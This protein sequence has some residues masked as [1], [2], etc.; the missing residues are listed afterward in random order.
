MACKRCGAAH[1]GMVRCKPE[2]VARMVVNKS[3]VANK[4]LVVNMAEIKRNV[5]TS[6][7]IEKS[8]TADRHKPRNEYMRAYM[9][10]RRKIEKGIAP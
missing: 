2:D 5:R 1:S 6:S 8:R 4:L 7:D 3:L 10:R 9:D